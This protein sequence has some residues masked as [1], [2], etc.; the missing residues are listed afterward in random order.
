MNFCLNCGKELTGTKSRNKYCDASCQQDYEQK[1][2]IEKWQNGEENGRKGA[3][4]ISAYVRSFMLKKVNYK[5]EKCGWGETN[6]FTKKIPLE[7]HHKDG[8]HENT[9]EKNLEVLCP[10]CHA[11]TENF[12]SRGGGREERKKYYMTNTC[13]D[14]GITISHTSVRCAVCELKHRKEEHLKTLPITR[15]ELKTKIRTKTFRQIGREL[16]VSDSTIKKWAFAY[17]LPNTKT[18]INQYTEEEWEVL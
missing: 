9:T 3:Y 7:I 5:C 1:Q 8:N 15:E 10:N 4:Q 18:S 17:G 12:R 2:Y 11:L 14:C 16:K 6:P 13:V